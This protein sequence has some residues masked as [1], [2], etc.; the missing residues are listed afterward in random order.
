[1]KKSKKKARKLRNLHAIAAWFRNSAGAFK[2][3]KKDKKVRRQQKQKK[4]GFFE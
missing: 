4:G 1:M 2:N 3:K